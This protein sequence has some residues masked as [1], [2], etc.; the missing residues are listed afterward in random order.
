MLYSLGRFAMMIVN[1]QA[2]AEGS[3]LLRWGFPQLDAIHMY[4]HRR[5]GMIF[6][7]HA[8]YHELYV[9]V[10]A[11]LLVC[12]RLLRRDV[13]RTGRRTGTGIGRPGTA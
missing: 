2:S 8:L 13:E 7:V 12:L 11:S 1:W 10:S 9:T 6:P 5:T 3:F 4:L